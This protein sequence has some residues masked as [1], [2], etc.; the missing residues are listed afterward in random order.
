MNNPSLI[1]PSSVT[2]LRPKSDVLRSACLFA[3]EYS[4]L[5]TSQEDRPRVPN[6]YITIGE[7]AP[8]PVRMAFRRWDLDGG[9]AGSPE[10]RDVQEV[11]DYLEGQEVLE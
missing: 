10:I 2:A 6:C 3:Q 5:I 8:E 11:L 4:I 1:R 7:G 9:K